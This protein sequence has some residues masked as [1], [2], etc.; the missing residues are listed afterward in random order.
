M[1][2]THHTRTTYTHS[3]SST[4]TQHTTRHVQKPKE[5]QKDLK[6]TNI[7]D[8]KRP[9]ARVGDVAPPGKHIPSL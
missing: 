8:Q 4:R 1:Q 5:L 2:H 7:V 9:E 6:W 3:R